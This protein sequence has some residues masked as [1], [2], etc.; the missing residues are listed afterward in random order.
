MLLS[1]LDILDFQCSG[2]SVTI[3]LSEGCD[4]VIEEATRD[5]GATHDG[6]EIMNDRSPS[7]PVGVDRMAFYS[8]TAATLRYPLPESFDSAVLRVERLRADSR[9]AHDYVIEAGSIVVDVEP[10]V[11][12]V[13]SW[14]AE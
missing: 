13:A 1:P 5:P 9:Q 8:E 14:R 11:P 4:I 2:H 12:V 10:G 7:A 3:T 6:V